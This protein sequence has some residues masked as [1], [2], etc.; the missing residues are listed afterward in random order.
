MPIPEFFKYDI[1]VR[2]RMLL[3]ERS[4]SGPFLL[5]GGFSICDIYAAMF[6]RWS[7]GKEWRAEHLKRVYD[8]LV[9]DAGAVIQFNTLLCDVETD[10]AVGD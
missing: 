3:I 9:T 6:S 4:I 8:N 10:Q 2:E 5:A 7:V 1:R